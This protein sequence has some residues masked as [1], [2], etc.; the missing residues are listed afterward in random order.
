M[1]ASPR[2]QRPGRLEFP[3]DHFNAV[4]SSLLIHHLPQ[5]Q[6]V[7]ALEEIRRA[8]KP[9]GMAPNLNDLIAQ[10]GFVEI[11]S[12]EGGPCLR[13]GVGAKASG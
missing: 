11:R 9:G 1:G 5:D 7:A 2:A 4:V 12:G 3:D 13:F 10:A 8:L 6:H